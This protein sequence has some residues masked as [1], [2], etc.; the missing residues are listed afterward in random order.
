VSKEDKKV[1]KKKSLLSYRERNERGLLFV[2]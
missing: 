1:C 2:K